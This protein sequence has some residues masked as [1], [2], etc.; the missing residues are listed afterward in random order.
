[1]TW[2]LVTRKRSLK[3]ANSPCISMTWGH[4]HFNEDFARE[5]SI[6][7]EAIRT[8]IYA[9]PETRRIGFE[10][11]TE[12]RP[13]SYSLSLRNSKRGAKGKGFRCSA[14]G[15]VANYGWVEA[16]IRKLPMKNRRF[17]PILESFE[18]KDLWVI[19]L[20]PAFEF[21]A[22]HHFPGHIPQNAV[23]V[24]Q[25]VRG[26]GENR[27]IVYIGSGKIQEG[28]GRRKN[29][30]FDWVEYSIIKDPEGQEKWRDYWISVYRGENDGE[31]PEYNRLE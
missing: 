29:W 9:N 3:R 26:G 15:V 10:F 18:G 24:Y 12:E 16:V 19:E 2:E 13:D 11:H 8:S 30:D 7:P 27:K 22:A 6:N 28:Y 14:R 23:G 17:R 25:Y 20:P 1:M 31:L 4:F 21:A 5:L